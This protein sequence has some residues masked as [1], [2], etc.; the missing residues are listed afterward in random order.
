MSTVY[1]VEQACLEMQTPLVRGAAAAQLENP[2][3]CTLF[4]NKVFAACLCAFRMRAAWCVE[5]A[6]A[7]SSEAKVR[8]TT[9]KA[10]IRDVDKRYEFSHSLREYRVAVSF[11][12]FLRDQP[13]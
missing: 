11:L 2:N 1:C 13:P 3:G 6:E 12:L 5:R 7:R 9:R 8:V 10:P 4:D